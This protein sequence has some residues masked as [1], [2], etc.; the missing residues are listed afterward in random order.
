MNAPDHSHPWHDV[1]SY[2]RHRFGCKV[3]KIQ[4]DT[5]Q[6]CPHKLDGSGG[7]VF[8][9]E[10][11]LLPENIHTASSL[12]E[13]LAQGKI[14]LEN[15]YHPAGYVAYFQRGTTTALPLPRLRE[16]LEMVLEDER[17]LAVA[18]GTRPDCLGEDVLNL[19]GDTARSRPVF[20]DLGLQSAHEETLRRIRRGH[21][22]DCFVRA[23][24]QLVQRPG[25]E[26]IA[27]M[28]LG[29]P[30]ETPAMMRDSFRFIA[31]LPLHG[32]KIH[33]LQVVRGTPLESMYQA[34]EVAVLTPEEY[35]PLLVDVL[36]LL[37]W[38][39]VIHRL[40]GDMPLRYLLAPRWSW[41]KDDIL[42]ALH[43]EFGIRGTRQ[44]AHWGGAV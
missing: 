13:Q 21:D 43:R 29:L 34:G 23:V 10:D 22:R 8:C 38:S 11:A 4:L 7:C 39:M 14:A 30:G 3:A 33:H 15:K 37:P 19:L 24:A 12:R 40:M 26:V 2:F 27:H 35:V 28:I 44:G 6:V 36:E 17:V 41:R 25:I 5:T 1:N 18:L 9:S 32:V 16:N 20:V 42:A 31:G